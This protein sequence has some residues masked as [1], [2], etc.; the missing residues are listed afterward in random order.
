MC[1]RLVV[2]KQVNLFQ[3]PRELASGAQQS[4]LDRWIRFIAS[5]GPTGIR[6]PIEEDVACL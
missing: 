1:S 4:I 5:L 2:L 3:N 6:E